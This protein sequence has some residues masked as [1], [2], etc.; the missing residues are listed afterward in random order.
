MVTNAGEAGADEPKQALAAVNAGK[1]PAIQHFIWSDA[2]Q[3]G[4]DQR[5]HDRCPAFHGQG[6]VRRIVS[7]A[8]LPTTRS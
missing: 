3:C 2:S 8:G 6:E 7:E 4:D 5:R 1:T